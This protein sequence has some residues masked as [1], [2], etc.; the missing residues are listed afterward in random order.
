[1]VPWRTGAVPELEL[2]D[3]FDRDPVKR[4]PGMGLAYLII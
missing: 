4:N 3:N 1:M 2:F